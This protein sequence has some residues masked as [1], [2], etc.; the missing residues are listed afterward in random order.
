MTAI[1][2]KW[3]SSW[4]V[5]VTLCWLTILFDGYDLTVYGTVSR[6]CWRTSRGS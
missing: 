1:H 4:V 6:P 3:R 5:V 2:Q